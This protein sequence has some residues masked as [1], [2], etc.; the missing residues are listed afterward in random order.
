[1]LFKMPYNAVKK[2]FSG[3][4][5]ANTHTVWLSLPLVPH[6]LPCC[7]F[8][9]LMSHGAFPPLAHWTL[10]FPPLI[11]HPSLLPVFTSLWL[12]LTPSRRTH[13]GSSFSF[14]LTLISQGSTRVLLLFL[15]TAYLASGLFLS[16]SATTL[17]PFPSFPFHLSVRICRIRCLFLVSSVSNM[18][19][20]RFPPSIRQGVICF[21]Q[22]NLASWNCYLIG[23]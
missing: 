5:G 22:R 3:K 17:L 12:P 16:S 4:R 6:W 19:L 23:V 11:P 20:F 21:C 8:L 1:M 14:S 10:L 15:L 18:F 13:T 2:H 7:V 9:L